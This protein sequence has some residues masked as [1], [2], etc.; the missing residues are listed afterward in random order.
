[1]RNGNDARNFVMPCAAQALLACC[2]PRKLYDMASALY[3]LWVYTA[4]GSRLGAI[5]LKKVGFPK[6]HAS[7]VPA[8]DAFAFGLDTYC[9]SSPF[10]L[11]V[12]AG[13]AQGQAL[14]LHVKSSRGRQYNF[15]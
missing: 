11:R 6:S 5:L 13:L 9:N 3:A 14:T 12:P 15:N 1:M 4:K 7:P 10:G 8:L 2:L